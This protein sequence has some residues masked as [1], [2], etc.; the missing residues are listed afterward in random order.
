MPTVALP[1]YRLKR[2]NLLLSCATLAMAAA[3]LAPQQAEAQAFQGTPTTASGTISY[4]R[5]TPGAET[6]NVGSATA[7][8]N[9]APS[10]A[11]GS[12]NIN[13]LPNGNTAT[14]QGAAGLATF[15][16]LNRIV[17][18]DVTRKIELNGS[19]LSK[20]SDATTGGNV[21]FYSPGGI[22]VG[23]GAVIDVGGLLLSSI[24]LPN[25]FTPSSSGFTATFSK[26][27]P[28]AGSIQV[29]SGAH[30]NARNN[31]VALVGPR[32]EQ[33]G[34][35][36]V[37]GSAGFA[38]ADGM[39]MTLSQ[40]FFDIEVPVDQGT[41]DP[42]GIVHTGTT[43]GPA[44]VGATDNHSIYMVAVPKNNA[45]TML[46]GGSIGFDAAAAGA[47]V[48][49]GQ[50]F[51]SSGFGFNDVGPV[52]GS[53]GTGSI[54]IGAPNGASFTSPVFGEADGSILVGATG[55]NVSFTGGDLALSR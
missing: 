37:N 38:A 48:Q 13:F 20:L 22:L 46:L 47:V 39:T 11:N 14:Y 27:Q 26:T 53:Q 12:G 54:N 42:N 45:L 5:A 49:N 55:G 15:T 10:D 2:Q 29:L 3:S 17:P 19:V 1:A 35:I 18:T 6:V 8:I 33:G 40:G 30:I 34:N 52:G 24:D 4:D 9:W 25:G 44:N 36:Q 31:Y 50:I 32:I 41:S 51:L 21:W 28:N 43:G 23:A 7:T 16:V